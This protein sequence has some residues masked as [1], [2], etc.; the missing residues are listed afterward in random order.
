M[1]DVV[2]GLPHDCQ[3]LRAHALGIVIGSVSHLTLL[4]GESMDSMNL[5][6]PQSFCQNSFQCYLVSGRLKGLLALVE[7][8]GAFLLLIPHQQSLTVELG[9]VFMDFQQLS[10]VRRIFGGL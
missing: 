8:P 6:E 1:P 7:S 4:L 9:W 2:G 3:S 10:V 5:S